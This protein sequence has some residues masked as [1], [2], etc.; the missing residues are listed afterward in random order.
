MKVV[1][2]EDHTPFYRGAIISQE[3]LYQKLN[4]IHDLKLPLISVTRTKQNLEEVFMHL[5]HKT[6]GTA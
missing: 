6:D 2:K 1:E 5:T 3:E 4:V